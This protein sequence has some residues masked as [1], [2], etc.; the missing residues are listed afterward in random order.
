MANAAAGPPR[1]VPTG[2]GLKISTVTVPAA[3][4]TAAAESEQTPAHY[5]TATGVTAAIATGGAGPSGSK[6]A[7]IVRESGYFCWTERGRFSTACAVAVHPR[8]GEKVVAE[9]GAHAIRS[10]A[11]ATGLVR[12][13]AGGV[14]GCADG[15][16]GAAKFSAPSGL[17]FDLRGDNLFIA[18]TGNLRIRQLR[19][20]DGSVRTI[21]GSGL[22]GHVD[23]VGAEVQ[24]TRPS[25]LCLDP[26][27]G[28]LIVADGHC[29]RLMTPNAPAADG[30]SSAAPASWSVSTLAGSTKSGYAEGKG[31][32]ALFCNIGGVAVDNASNIIVADTGV[33]KPRSAD[34][35]MG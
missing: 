18:D 21:A 4:V 1:V 12:V 19:L 23:G 26:V 30:K 27:T 16:A 2:S 35:S 31:P 8:T 29:I 11:P 13:V 17:C 6:R 5:G 9:L 22:E 24:F 25:N 14:R 28:E 7:T 33:R 20:D 3:L 32:D 34:A 10:I 15:P